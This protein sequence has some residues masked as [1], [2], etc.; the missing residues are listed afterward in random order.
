MD[1]HVDFP[2]GV[3]PRTFVNWIEKAD[4]IHIKAYIT[5]IINLYRTPKM[6]HKN[7]YENS[8]KPT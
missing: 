8:L 3:T 1:V 6:S 5:P 2:I 4:V 7:L